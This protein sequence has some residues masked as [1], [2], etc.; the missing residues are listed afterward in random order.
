M[1]IF[2]YPSLQDA[3]LI[4]AI[5][6]ALLHRLLLNSAGGGSSSLSSS[7]VSPQRRR[8]S[9]GRKT[10][11][12]LELTIANCLGRLYARLAAAAVNPNPL[13]IASTVK[14]HAS[15]AVDYTFFPLG[16]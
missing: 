12:G 6:L 1:S 9:A 2:S 5:W 7:P 10:A 15:A 4:E 8:L 3:D 11:R 16:E 13:N 14:L